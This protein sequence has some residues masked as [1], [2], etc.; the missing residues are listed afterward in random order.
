[1]SLLHQRLKDEQPEVSEE[2]MSAEDESG[3][4]NYEQIRNNIREKLLQLNV[5]VDD[6]DRLEKSILEMLN[7]DYPQ[8]SRMQRQ[9]LAGVI[10]YDIAGYGPIQ[11]LIDDPEVTDI[12]VNRFD[13][14]YYERNGTEYKYKGRFY[15]EKHLRDVIEKIVSRVGRRVDESSPIEGARL[16]DGSRV[17]IVLPPVAVDG[18]AV[19]IRRFRSDVT[20]DKLIEWGVLTRSQINLLADFVK[21]RLNLVISGG[22]G[23][24]KTTLL[25][26]LSK[27]IDERVAAIEDVA[28]LTL[29]VP[30][31]VRF[32]TR[33]PNIEGKGEISQ[34]AL[35]K[36]ALRK[37]P[38]RIIVGECRA[39]EAFQM[40]QAM[41]TG[42][43]GSL[44]TA[45]ANSPEDCIYRIKDMV[46]MS[47]QGSRMNEHSIYSQIGQALHIVVQL[48]R[49]PSGKRVVTR[50]SEIEAKNGAQARDVYL[51]RKG[52]LV[53]VNEFSEQIHELVNFS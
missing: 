43:P 41:N 28:E 42:H 20:E 48:D 52:K 45:H 17:Q 50:I 9:D 4:Y 3:N 14:I 47:E 10:A 8:L 44:T 26:V 24:G 18:A 36:S 13:E 46:L 2:V 19:T 7:N 49:L 11:P 31:M 32:E 27:Y 33:P 15:N 23:T 35:L 30:N 40:L 25:N 51:W 5:P 22:T 21:A 38:K 16:P 12:M 29:D 34:E 6:R 1:M 37:Y 39:G 53:K